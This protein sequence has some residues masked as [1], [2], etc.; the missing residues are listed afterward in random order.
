MKSNLIEIRSYRVLNSILLLVICS[1]EI[2][3]LKAKRV[4]CKVTRCYL[5]LVTCPTT[6]YASPLEDNCV[7]TILS[8]WR[9]IDRVDI[10]EYLRTEVAD[11][12]RRM[13]AT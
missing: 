13:N 12:I 7:I 4:T 6:N 1:I 11:L 9:P 8:A 2:K 3:K 10:V 5:L